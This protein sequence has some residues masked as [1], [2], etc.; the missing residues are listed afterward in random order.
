MVDAPF[1]K[2]EVGLI[3]GGLKA[4]VV[5]R[6]SPCHDPPSTADYVEYLYG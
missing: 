5:R 3:E 1:S 4:N 6:A 2:G